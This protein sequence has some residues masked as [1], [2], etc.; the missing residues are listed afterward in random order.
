[1]EHFDKLFYWH[2]IADSYYNYRGDLV[3]V[4]FENKLN[5]INAMGVDT[6]DPEKTAQN[7]YQLDVAPWQ[8]WLLDFAVSYQGAEQV[9]FLQV[10]PHELALSFDYQLMQGDA[11]LAAGTLVPQDFAEVGDYAFEG[12]RYSRRAIPVPNVP[13]GYHSLSVSCGGKTQ[14]ACYA[15][16]PSKAY[17]SPALQNGERV[18]G[19][20]VQL[21]TLTSSRNWGI[22]DFTDLA[23]LIRKSAALGVQMIGLNPLHALLEP[24]ADNCSPYSPSD[25]R[26]NNPLYIDPEQE[27][28]F[29]LDIKNFAQELELLRRA[30]NVPYGPLAKLKY[31]C[32][33]QMFEV[34]CQ[35]ELGSNSPRD[36]A[37][38]LFVETQGAALEDFCIYQVAQELNL[39]APWDD[40]E[41]KAAFIAEHRQKAQFHA[42]LQWLADKQLAACQQLATSLGM[43]LGLMRDLAVGANGSGSEVSSH[44]DLFCREAAVGAPPDPLAEQGQNWGLPPMDPASLRLSRFSHFIT[45][46]RTNM[47]HCGALRI[48]HAMSLLRLWWCPPGTTADH[49]AYVYYPFHELMALLKLESHLNRCMVIGED[50][51]VVPPE[52]R[53]A[54]YDGDIFTNKLFYFEKDPQGQFKHP[55][56][57]EPHSLAMVTNHDVPTL[58]AWWNGQDLLLRQALK[59]YPPEVNLGDLQAGRR[60][61]KSQLL[62]WL[63]FLGFSLPGEFEAVLDGPLSWDLCALILKGANRCRSQLFVVQLEDLE[64]LDTPVNVPGTCFEYPNWQ[65]KL[66]KPLEAVFADAQVGQLLRDLVA[67]RAAS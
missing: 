61:E 41:A 21:Y 25:R 38:Q 52:L 28:D 27:S 54:L 5:I 33:R 30:S 66:A 24:V 29:R 40:E 58:T 1:M 47:A 7:A 17:V 55:D 64:L 67:D 48:D 32:F 23:F 12:V 65:R 60:Y 9:F 44:L 59:L 42:Y 31:A 56:H 26:F 20:I 57:Y 37:F 18:L 6:S 8:Q 10:A 51:G 19:I 11:C 36:Q 14:T 43:G 45:L 34:F 22:G 15:V 50:M 13:L 35:V 39:A 16:A 53:Q 2:G 49:G 46:L 3:T 62:N 4:P 63:I